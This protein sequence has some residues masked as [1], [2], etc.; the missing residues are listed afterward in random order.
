MQN[1]LAALLGGAGAGLQSY[2]Q[3]AFR[4]QEV[5][6][7]QRQRMAEMEQQEQ[8]R[9]AVAREAAALRQ[10][11][12]KEEGEQAAVI[13]RTMGIALPE[14]A[15]LNTQGVQV[16]AQ[17]AANTRLATAQAGAT[18]RNNASIESRLEGLDRSLRG[19]MDQIAAQGDISKAIAAMGNAT[20]RDIA[21]TAEQGRADR[22]QPKSELP[23]LADMTQKILAQPDENG[24]RRS[25]EAAVAEAKRVLDLLMRESGGAPPSAAAGAPMR[26][27]GNPAEQELMV[28]AQQKIRSIMADRSLS[29]ED[30]QDMIQ[31]VN[32]ILRQRTAA[33]RGGR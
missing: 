22:F 30:Q 32:D 20:R 29:P 8:S 1:I 26:A 14:G 21:A 10:Q 2:G 13:A 4:Q 11:Q 7:A 15:R 25:P 18:E 27:A 6:Q 12:L 28:K 16:L 24:L 5:Q 33:L 31:Q 23:S 9:I 3:S 19:R 17:D